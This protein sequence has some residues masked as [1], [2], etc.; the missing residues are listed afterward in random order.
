MRISENFFVNLVE[1]GMSLR[2]F[3]SG[4]PAALREARQ[5]E[6]DDREKE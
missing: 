2:A 3:I 1:N 6:G 5:R 4:R